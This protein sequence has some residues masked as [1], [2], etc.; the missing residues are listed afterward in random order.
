MP[1]TLD[2]RLST[3]SIRDPETGREIPAS[4]GVLLRYLNQPAQ[5]EVV[6]SKIRAA[7]QTKYQKA[8]DEGTD[9]TAAAAELQADL[10]ALDT[11]SEQLWNDE[12]SILKDTKRYRGIRDA[13]RAFEQRLY[14]VF[15]PAIMR[16]GMVEL[17]ESNISQEPTVVAVEDRY[18]IKRL[19]TLRSDTDV[20]IKDAKTQTKIKVFLT[21]ANLE[22]INTTLRHILAMCKASPILTIESDLLIDVLI[23]KF[24]TPETMNFMTEQAL[25]DGN[26]PLD[27]PLDR[28]STEA[29]TSF[30]ALKDVITSGDEAQLYAIAKARYDFNKDTDAKK[31]PPHNEVL[32]D[33]PSYGVALPV[34]LEEVE[35]KANPDGTHVIDAVLTFRRI[36]ENAYT[37]G[38]LQWR[39]A[40]GFPTFDMSMCTPLRRYY[41]ITY[42]ED[43]GDDKQTYLVPIHPDETKVKCPLVMTWRN[44]FTGQE[45]VLDLTNEEVAIHNIAIGWKNKLAFLPLIG[46]HNPAVQHL[47]VANSMVQMQLVTKS[48]KIVREFN[49]LKDEVDQ[50]RRHFS[51]LNRDERV[52][53]ENG[54]V[55]LVGAKEFVISSVSTQT[56]PRSSELVY[57][58][59]T[60]VESKYTL[61]EREQVYLYQDYY[62]PKHVKALWDYMFK[63]ARDAVDKIAKRQLL[64]T[65]EKQVLGIL[66]GTGI[67]DFD[68][69]LRRRNG[70]RGDASTT[71]A[72]GT[73]KLPT[74]VITKEGQGPS[75]IAGVYKT[76]GDDANGILNQYVLTAGLVDYYT[77]GFDSSFT[78]WIHRTGREN[79]GGVSAVWERLKGNPKRSTIRKR[80]AKLASAKLER[81]LDFDTDDGGASRRERLGAMDNL[82]YTLRESVAGTNSPQSA[83]TFRV[84]IGQDGMTDA[85]WFKQKFWDSLYKVIEFRTGDQ[86]PNRERVK[87]QA[88]DLA[89]AHSYLIGILANGVADQWP[90]FDQSQFLTERK[91]QSLSRSDQ[92]ISSNYP[93]LYLPRYSEFFAADPLFDERTFPDFPELDVAVQDTLTLIP[94]AGETVPA[95]VVDVIDGDTIELDDGRRVRLIGINAPEAGTIEGDAATEI[96]TEVLLGKTVE[97]EIDDT[98][99]DDFG[100]TLAYVWLGD[101]MVNQFM[102]ASGNADRFSFQN[103]DTGEF[104]NTKYNG[105]FDQT[106]LARKKLYGDRNT[107]GYHRGRIL[108][109]WR[110]FAPRWRDLGVKPPFRVRAAYGNLQD[111]L[112]ELA[113]EPKDYVEPGFFYWRTPWK[114]DL[115]SAQK[116][117]EEARARRQETKQYTITLDQSEWG[118]EGDVQNTLDNLINQL[119]R[120]ARV[121][122]RHAA[123]RLA[124]DRGQARDLLKRINKKETDVPVINFIDREGRLIAYAVHAPGSDT[125]AR[126]RHFKVVKFKGG[127]LRIRNPYDTS[128][129]AHDEMLST[130]GMA[131]VTGNMPDDHFSPSRA[132]PTYRVYAIEEDRESLVYSDDFYGINCVSS[133]EVHHSKKNA[134]LAVLRITN[135]SGSFEN[136]AFL[137]LDRERLREISAD[138]EGEE[139]Y[140]SFRFRTGTLIQIRQGY[141]SKAED[142]PIIFS[143]R[144]VEVQFGPVITLICQGHRTEMYQDIEMALSSKD[145]FQILDIAFRKI[146]PAPSLGR[147]AKMGEISNK[148][149][150]EALGEYAAKKI[151]WWGSLWKHEISSHMRNVFVQSNSPV[152]KGWMDVFKEGF[153]DE[154]MEATKT[155][156]KRF[157]NW[158]PAI[159]LLV[160]D[161]SFDYWV[162]PQ[163]PMWN[164]VQEMCRHMPGTIAHVVPFEQDGTLFF[165]KPTTPYIFENPPLAQKRA[166]NKM[167]N[168]VKTAAVQDL[169]VL[170]LNRFLESRYFID[171]TVPYR[172]RKVIDT[173]G[174]IPIG[175]HVEWE[176]DPIVFNGS[177]KIKTVQDLDRWSNESFRRARFL[178]G[179]RNDGTFGDMK[180]A[181]VAALLDFRREWDYIYRYSPGLARLMVAFWHGLPT[182]GGVWAGTL[183]G[184]W[185]KIFRLICAPQKTGKGRNVPWTKHWERLEG[186]YFDNPN[187]PLNIDIADVDY[188]QLFSFGGK[189]EK[190][191]DQL[192][193]GT[194]ELAHADVALDELEATGRF[195]K[196]TIDELRD[197]IRRRKEIFAE[198]RVETAEQ[199][200]AQVNRVKAALET[201]L[202]KQSRSGK[203]ES[204]KLADVVR[205]E[206]QAFRLLVHYMA[207]YLR[208]SLA[209]NGIESKLI[210]QRAMDEALKDSR[211][212]MLPPGWKQFRDYHVVT[213][214]NDIIENKITASMAEMHNAVLI[215]YP[216][217]SPETSVG[218]LDEDT[219]FAN[220]NSQFEDERI[221][222]K[223]SQVW[224]SYPKTG[225]LPFR[226]TIGREYRK[227][228]VRV[229]N[230]ANSE[231]KAA[232]VLISNMAAAIRPMY[233]G[234]LLIVG[235]PM[236]PYD[237]IHIKDDFTDMI[238]PV[239]V[240][241]VV[242]HFNVDTGWVTTVVP[243]ALVHANDNISMIQ[244]DTMMDWLGGVAD[245]YQKNWL[246]VEV[247]LWALAAFTGGGSLA[248]GA[249]LRGAGG[250]AVRTTARA[251]GRKGLKRI[252]VNQ[253]MRRAFFRAARSTLGR[254]GGRAATT[255]AGKTAIKTAM[256]RN[257]NA[258]FGALGRYLNIGA[259]VG[260][261]VS[262]FLGVS[263]LGLHVY[264]S[265]VHIKAR[266]GNVEVP[267]TLHPLILKG[268]PYTAGLE[269][270]YDNTYS[271]GERIEGFF[272][273]LFDS[274]KDGVN[275]L[276]KLLSNDTE[277][278]RE[279]RL[280]EEGR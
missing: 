249:L 275:R 172:E 174:P 108:P 190:L 242:H 51:H 211:S 100:R 131:E 196:S 112:D 225:G 82:G 206:S 267:V 1:K 181:G 240:D 76:P 66:F 136:D 61:R 25:K 55:N 184:D 30:D 246:W 116:I 156:L 218:D 276:D 62:S 173:I 187:S 42:L 134:S 34:A 164:M 113:R 239:E 223:E 14:E 104:E 137:D 6:I 182:T 170:V 154:Y 256:A 44:Y 255:T 233:R 46:Q 5:L 27:D 77:K 135:T 166:Y 185:P 70:W 193:V 141:T 143:G 72:F 115:P 18:D 280:L 9:P 15:R 258:F 129:L 217:G 103:Q 209:K 132:Y 109:V 176:I 35:L 114:D 22:Q 175:G 219:V 128:V 10:A 244:H 153:S 279:I 265:T 167:Y 204:A 194:Q 224:E 39:T 266:W 63:V 149:A 86:N 36:N 2:D 207:L 198:F 11:L 96:L 74:N 144:V 127:T 79:E 214:E 53:V 260:Q 32:T 71:T 235:R 41:R 161:E 85:P 95:Q 234:T 261:A 236:K 216:D 252:L 4:A 277:G 84:F 205:A 146:G 269:Y 93:D 45:K 163:Q 257:P 88:D 178:T 271:F 8:I 102:L 117:G 78:G 37:N 126:T 158:I 188:N 274:A 91:F 89:Q 107:S 180:P 123:A 222:F 106:V 140:S 263:A 230:N 227:L 50:I 226:P 49:M 83:D 192:G 248:I 157:A 169:S 221:V 272:Q 237:V 99:F 168:V 101:V 203:G 98:E 215:R 87:W 7:A 259:R 145:P 243:C 179:W 139:Y 69:T 119:L 3:L 148:L 251:L 202:G 229:E 56:D 105:S 118:A 142:L 23:N 262:P 38:R 67:M 147:S 40:D 200:R 33:R 171:P 12:A 228:L 31:N 138:D 110:N 199:R 121:D 130:A 241:E 212:H 162:C 81:V 48:R 152:V 43:N 92:D 97:I 201:V 19:G 165:G 64:D 232:R 254:A 60:L 231:G 20:V 58:T 133:I 183:E 273:H 120:D 250:L 111:A 247:G 197:Q 73:G 28:L 270:G 155:R 17:N 26:V 75:G 16:I 268:R 52:V 21:F 59:V 220:P 160:P 90:G 213:S 57:I 13:A 24:G 159:E 253:T 264:Y 177:G 54:L 238:G 68:E 65:H 245:W 151:N 122:Q 278:A 150:T 94:P 29:R 191:V 80:R 124:S 125:N 208:R 210:R 189:I 195:P 47:G 186:Q